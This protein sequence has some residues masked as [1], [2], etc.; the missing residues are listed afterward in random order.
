[1]PEEW[2]SLLKGRRSIRVYKKR[3]VQTSII[4]GL[5]E[6]ATWAPSAHNSQPW[7][8][9]V[10]EDRETKLKLAEAMANRWMED[11]K[12]D[13]VPPEERL[14]L[15][16]ESIE[17]FVTAPVLIMGCISLEDMD[18]YPDSRRQECERIM[19]TQS[20]SAAIQNLLLAS[21]AYGLGACWC[22]APLFCRDEVK[23]TL[24]IPEGAEPQALITVGYPA[25]RVEPPPRFPLEKVMFKRRWGEVF[26]S[27]SRRRGWR[28]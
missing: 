8:F 16:H 24:G 19:A 25:E 9:I 1:M 3:R 4:K 20:L 10:I 7:R 17:R 14:R 6:A 26:D 28:S 22:C 5:I 13:G 27:F 18:K 23:E 11:L 12:C 21:S 15:K 2:V